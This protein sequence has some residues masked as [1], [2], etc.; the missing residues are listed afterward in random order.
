MFAATWLKVAGITRR[1]LP[2]GAH[3]TK[4]KYILRRNDR[5]TPLRMLPGA[6]CLNP[7]TAYEVRHPQVPYC[8]RSAAFL[9]KLRMDL[10]SEA[11]RTA[12]MVGRHPHTHRAQRHRQFPLAP[13]AC[14]TYSCRTLTY[15]VHARAFPTRLLY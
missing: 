14:G 8:S 1:S 11:S 7:I 2:C 10:P 9:R 4:A 13:S 3:R 6:D 15:R 5:K 12:M